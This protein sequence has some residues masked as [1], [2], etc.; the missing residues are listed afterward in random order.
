MRR[1]RSENGGRLLSRSFIKG[2]IAGLVLLTSLTVCPY[3]L[4]SP[5][6]L[7]TGKTVSLVSAANAFFS[8]LRSWVDGFIRPG[9]LTRETRRL[10]K[11]VIELEKERIRLRELEEENMRL[12]RLVRMAGKVPEPCRT[13]RVIAVGG[14]NWFRT[15]VV[16]AGAAEGCQL[17]S[18]VVDCWGVVGRL[19]RVHPHHSVIL[20]ATDK[21]SVVGVALEDHPG[22]YGFVKG[23]G[24][25]GAVLENLSRF[26]VPRKGERLTT[27]GLG[28]IFPKGIPV[29]V[30]DEVDS[31]SRRTVIRV[32]LSA[33]I[34]DLQEVLI[35]TGYPR[36]TGPEL[37]MPRLATGTLRSR[38][39]IGR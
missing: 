6:D 37:L 5:A 12:R 10:R 31:S 28:E 11:M 3:L 23:D 27:S 17:G 24:R 15:A 2:L 18:P 33:R 34:N 22:I 1:V 32:R 14:S 21:R 29:G 8:S 35:V 30:V 39:S 20:L 9:R 26:A 16:D 4:S 13:A 25:F 7:L 19:L 38:S 36:K